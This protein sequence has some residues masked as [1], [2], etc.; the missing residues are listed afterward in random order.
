MLAPP[1]TLPSSANQT[2]NH[3]RIIVATRP[4]PPPSHYDY[5]DLILDD[6]DIHHDH[7][8]H[9]IHP[10]DGGPHP[11]SPLLPT[12]LSLLPLPFILQNSG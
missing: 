12:K 11:L 3:H 4:L 1:S 2:H 9:H 5:D 10:D 7:H 8:D 6:H